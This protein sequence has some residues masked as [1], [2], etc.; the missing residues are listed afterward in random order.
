[1]LSLNLLKNTEL[2]TRNTKHETKGQELYNKYICLSLANNNTI[3]HYKNLILS[4]LFIFPYLNVKAKTVKQ[5]FIKI[6]PSGERVKYGKFKIKKFSTKFDYVKKNLIIDEATTNDALLWVNH[7]I[8]NFPKEAKVLFFIHGF[9]ASLPYSLNRSTKKFEKYYFT[10]D[11]SNVC[12]IIHIIW[13]ANSINYK[14]AVK[15]LENSTKTLASLIN[16]IPQ[17]IDHKY[18]L[19]CHSMGNRFLF[20]TISKYEI[21]TKFE[22]L[23]LMAPDLDYRKYE[24]HSYLFT[25]LA[26]SVYIFFHVKDKT[27]LMSKT[28]NGIE[29][30]GRMKKYKD[31]TNIH[32]IDCSDL[33]DIDDIIDMYNK[34]IY[35]LNSKTIR[36][37]LEN[38]LK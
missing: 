35:F 17:T 3:M 14:R 23:I 22:E 1:M 27:L 9:W 33:N 25:N 34:H 20:E 36:K 21:S 19:M 24:K 32:F 2:E 30:L 13:D 15:S 37:M 28:Y 31:N 5:F 7:E 26:S 29:R 8:Q 10:S 16:N 12:A 38:I 18:S 11:S 4:V 6:S